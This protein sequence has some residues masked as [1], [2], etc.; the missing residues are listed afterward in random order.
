MEPRFETL[1]E[2]KLVG[3][4]KRM[5]FANN[6]T[7]ELWHGFI[8]RR[9]E[10]K[11]NV[12]EE[13]FSLEIYDNILFFKNFNPA[14]EFAKWAAIEVSNFNH[15]PNEMETMIIPS[16]S[17]AVFIHKGPASEGAKTYNYIFSEW[18]P[19]SNY[20]LDERPHFALMNGKYKND[21]PNSEEEIWI[22]VK[23]KN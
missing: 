7:K 8:P 3:K 17:Y 18:M 1:K 4:Q 15:V 5:S 23:R 16:G 9:N 22:P 11:N 14:N 10:I 19:K 12:S 21:D 20:D 13:L 6:T 2:K